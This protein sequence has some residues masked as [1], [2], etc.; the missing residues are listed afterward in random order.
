MFIDTFPTFLRHWNGSK[1]SWLRYIQEY[2][3]LFEKI[4]WDYERYG[5][6]WLGGST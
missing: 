1:E 3:E 5:M 6:D 2:P 4:K